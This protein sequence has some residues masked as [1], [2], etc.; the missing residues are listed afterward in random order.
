M[1]AVA[2]KLLLVGLIL[3]FGRGSVLQLASALF[4][5]T[6]FMT[7]Q[8]TFSPF[9]LP[10][11]NLL[12]LSTELHT[13][14]TILIAFTI[15]ADADAG[16]N[17]SL[18]DAVIVSTFMAL[19]VLPFVAVVTVKVLRVRKLM[20]QALD[21]PS[22]RDAATGDVHMAIQRFQLG[23]Q[24][25]ADRKVMLEYFEKPGA[26]AQLWRDKVIASHL[27]AAEMRDT[28]AELEAQLP[29]SQALGYHF[30]DLDSV[31]LV[32]G[33]IGIR[34]STVGQLGGGV[35]ICLAS[36]VALGWC[37]YGDESFTEAVGKGLWGS[38]W[39]E[40]MSGEPWPDLQQRVSSGKVKGKWP[41]ARDEWGRWNKK[42]E[43][44]FV[45][46]IPSEENRDRHRLLPGRDDV[47]ILP[48]SD[49]VPDEKEEYHFYP[50]ENIVAC[51]IL[52]A[53]DKP[54]RDVLSR[55]AHGET[56]QQV[57][58]SSTR[59]GHGGMQGV[60][61]TALESG[62]IAA[63]HENIDDSSGFPPKVLNCV[64][65]VAQKSPN[66]R[67]DPAA[68]HRAIEQARAGA[69]L[70]P[71]DISRFTTEEMEYGLY[72]VDQALL[73]SYSLA[74][75]YTSKANAASIYEPDSGI[76]PSDGSI[77]VCTQSP[78]EL[79]WE[80]NGG[81]SFRA[82]VGRTMWDVGPVDVSAGGRLADQLEVMLVVA[83]PTTALEEK[84]NRG[85]ESLCTIP[86][87]FLT[88]AGAYSNAHIQKCYE[89]GRLDE[90]AA[91]VFNPMDS[92]GIGGDDI[93]DDGEPK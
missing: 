60:S 80:K 82:N 84:R 52:T 23:L 54:G 29:K 25:A 15:K 50:N 27:T 93:N 75:Y 19:V 31:K 12:R 62:A 55:L 90:E 61:L 87:S 58:L 33:S 63:D 59:D 79:G 32:L 20:H 18:Y 36:P 1:R 72:A 45:V 7:A 6:L 34:A 41:A 10:L 43:A 88:G 56:Q 71:E 28:L 78:V 22:A 40:V 11:D 67:G 85:R 51:F 13:V 9:K 37:E 39:Y 74:Y 48:K 91:I 73:R 17:K 26:G 86:Q 47:F 14:I 4:V 76:A 30:T 89:L 8:A 2:R 53:P 42:L 69:R 64:A 16:S 46:K 83:V 44:M 38:K 81:G 70:W 3:M 68:T 49:C 24:D 5:A 92:L 65:T 21:D 77:V 57:V 66:G 35:S